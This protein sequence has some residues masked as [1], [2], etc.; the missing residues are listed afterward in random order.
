MQ[1]QFNT[2]KFLSENSAIVA[3]ILLFIISVFLKGT[4]F[5]NLRNLTNI[6]LNNSIIGIVSL[7]MTLIIITGGIDLSVGSQLA[8][9]GL[10]TISVLNNTGSIIA[11]ILAGIAMGTVM[12]L[13]TG[14]LV[15]KCSIPAFIVTLGTMSIYR[16]VAQY[17]FKGG[18]I[19]AQGDRVDTFV[20]ISNTRIFGL[21][22]LPILYWLGLSI[23]V[24]VFTS[25]AATGRHIYA[26]GSNEKA[27]KLSGINTDK[28]K[29][30]TY[31]I[32]GALVAT[33]AV[34][35]ASR[36]GSMNS[37]SSG[38]SYEMDAIAAVVIGGTSM[39]GGRGRVIGTVFGT[40]TLGLIDNMMNMLGVPTFL[41]SA[42]KGAIIILAVLFQRLLDTDK[43]R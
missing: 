7:G 21:I 32:S 38:T 29:I 25:R 28:V 13:A 37:A 18:G 14:T 8:A 9:T 15:S 27:A 19:L 40:L 23:L 16:S 34:V 10:F 26:V 1:K 17:F 42:I 41:V 24:A 11:G 5:L 43:D 33:A 2:K 30:I 4:T 39:S 22:P 3:F 36:L 6:F 35:E 20:A 31:M 12:G